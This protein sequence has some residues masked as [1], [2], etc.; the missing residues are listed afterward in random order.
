MTWRNPPDA[1]LRELLQTSRTIAVVGCSPDP[2]R[3]SHQ[4]ARTM[5]QRGYRIVP[6]NP[7]HAGTILGESTYPDLESVPLPID[8]VD[9]F[10]RSELVVS[11]AEGAVRVRA[12]ALWLQQGVVNE[13]A[14]RI[15]T[16]AGLVCV[17]DACLAVYH[18]MLL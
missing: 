8:I 13:E 1:V 9:V 17:M 6:V 16:E 11:V 18:R 5:Q 12:R 10:R 14:A 15:A 3:T 4:I 7:T 2:S